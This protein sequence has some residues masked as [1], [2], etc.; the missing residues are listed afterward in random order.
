MFVLW[1]FVGLKVVVHGRLVYAK[2]YC[3]W[4]K[5]GTFQSVDD[6]IAEIDNS[7][8]RD[9]C[10]LN[11]ESWLIVH[12]SKVVFDHISDDGYIAK[13]YTEAGPNYLKNRKD[14]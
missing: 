12:D 11:N 1:V 5:V 3:Y 13:I 9:N 8:E 6:A 2:N 10:R 14:S 4:K 7:L